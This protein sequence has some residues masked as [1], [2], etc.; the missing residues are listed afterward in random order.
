MLHVFAT[1][2]PRRWLAAA[3][4]AA[5]TALLIGLPTDL[6][7]NPVF[8]RQIEAEWWSMPVLVVTSVL[9]GLLFATYVRNDT[10]MP[11][12]GD[13]ELDRPAKTGGLGGLISFFAV[14]CPTCNKVVLL[15]LGTTGA[16]DWF[17]PAQ[18]ILAVLSIVLLAWALRARLR[19][20]VA[21]RIAA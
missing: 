2:S 17:A 7:P 20:E 11:D 9:A 12:V 18:P 21:C 5:V 10:S 8:G 4:G 3:A 6:I 16:L 13:D 15:A 19:G 1:W 14:G